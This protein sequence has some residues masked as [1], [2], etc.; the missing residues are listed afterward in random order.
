MKRILLSAILFPIYLSIAN[1]E[2]KE[3]PVE[4][5][6]KTIDRINQ[7][8]EYEKF[9]LSVAWV[10][11]RLNPNAVGDAMDWGLYQIT[12][13][14]LA[15]YNQKTGSSYTMRDM[16]DPQISRQIFD[17]YSKGKPF[18]EAARRWNRAYAWKDSLGLQYWILVQN[19]LNNF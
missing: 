18:E 19:K 12:P 13:I 5:I 10:E 14:R 7:E 8:M 3:P 16:F 17:F 15:D 1:G 4:N 2:S 6:Q 11:S 9:A